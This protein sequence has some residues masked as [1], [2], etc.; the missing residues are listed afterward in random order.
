MMIGHVPQGHQFDEMI[1]A[2]Y[3]SEK[4]LKCCGAW[5][6]CLFIDRSQGCEWEHCRVLAG[7]V[8]LHFLQQTKLVHVNCAMMCRAVFQRHT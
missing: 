8:P 5:S 4:L 1:Q 2:L 6:T 3:G 7:E